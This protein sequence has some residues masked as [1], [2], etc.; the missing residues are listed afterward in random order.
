MTDKMM[1]EILAD[2]VVLVDTREKKNGHVLEYF[3]DNGI[4]YEICKLDTADYCFT[5]PNYSELGL[6]QSILI[7]RKGSLDEL[8]GNFTKDRERFVREFERCGCNKVH[9]V[10]EG[11]TWKKILNGSYR[12]KFAPKSY[13]ASMLSFNVA[14]DCPMWF[15]TKEESGAVIYHLLYYGLRNKLKKL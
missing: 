4:K 8:A 15:V 10:V 1:A 11:A 2:I 9:M 6:D 14:Y 7:E 13:M 5:L 12:S 3:N